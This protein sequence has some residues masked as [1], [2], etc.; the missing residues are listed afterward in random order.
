VGG[1]ACWHESSAKVARIE[2][3]SKQNFGDMVRL[4]EASGL[5]IAGRFYARHSQ[6]SMIDSTYPIVDW[7]FS[8]GL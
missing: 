2:T 1:C 3:N 5:G 7:E 8:V 4:L 6:K